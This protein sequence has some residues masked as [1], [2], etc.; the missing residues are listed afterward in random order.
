MEHGISHSQKKTFRN[1]CTSPLFLR[2]HWKAAWILS[3][4]CKVVRL[5]PAVL[6]SFQV[7]S[8]MFSYEERNKQVF[9][10][11]K[12]LVKIVLIFKLLYVQLE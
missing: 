8:G 4:P 2:L 12:S 6:W 11:R 3:V 10:F 5:F 1:G 7:R 9:A